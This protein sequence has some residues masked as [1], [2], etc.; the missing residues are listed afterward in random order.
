MANDAYIPEFGDDDNSLEEC[1]LWYFEQERKEH[2][3]YLQELMKGEYYEQ[4]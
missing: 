2:E 3:A 4:R 1:A